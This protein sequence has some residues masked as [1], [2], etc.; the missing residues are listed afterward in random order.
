MKRTLFILPLIALMAA[1]AMAKDAGVKH[2][3]AK[4]K[5][6]VT[7]TQT[8]STDKTVKETKTTTAKTAKKRSKKVHKSETAT[9]AKPKTETKYNQ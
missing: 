7:A 9:S 5:T 4:A 3:A 6:E 1:P 2:H 8:Q